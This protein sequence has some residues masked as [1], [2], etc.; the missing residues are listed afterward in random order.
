M[1]DGFTLPEAKSE[2]AWRDPDSLFV[3]TDFGPGSLTDS[4][5]PRIVKVWKRGTPLAEAA[6][7][8]SKAGPTTS[9]SRP[10]ATS[11]RASSATSS[12]RAPD[13]YDRRDLPAAATASCV[14]STCPPTPRLA[15]PPRMAA[16]RAAH[17]L[18][19]WAARPAPPARCWRP[20][21]TAFLA[22]RAATSPLFSPP[23]HAVAG[24][25]QPGRGTT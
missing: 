16:R 12:V 14:R 3:G 23:P 2:V 24:R 13:F 17:R 9:A 22:G 25:L 21:S 5:Y 10:C 18:D 4:G 6:D 20:T 1:K 7:R 8:S 15:V 19:A 11:R